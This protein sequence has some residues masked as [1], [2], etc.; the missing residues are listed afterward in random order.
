M[1][2]LHVHCMRVLHVQVTGRLKLREGSHCAYSLR[3][4]YSKLLLQYE[5]HKTLTLT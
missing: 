4:Q 5:L 3:Q 1:R 2:V